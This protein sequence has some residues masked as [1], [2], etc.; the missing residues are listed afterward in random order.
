MDTSPFDEHW[1][2]RGV[3]GFKMLAEN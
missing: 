3:A 1:S 2:D